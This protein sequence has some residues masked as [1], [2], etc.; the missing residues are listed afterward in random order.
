ML[1]L[2]Y[3]IFKDFLSFV[4]F[5]REEGDSAALRP[6][7]FFLPCNVFRVEKEGGGVEEKE[8]RLPSSPYITTHSKS[9]L[10]LSLLSYI[11]V[12]PC[13]HP[14]FSSL[15]GL[16]PPPIHPSIHPLYLPPLTLYTLTLLFV[17]E[18]PT[19]KSR[20]RPH[21]LG[22]FSSSVGSAEL[23]VAALVSVDSFHF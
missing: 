13:T 7:L 22:G 1:F 10:S 21:E 5:S 3:S 12:A 11:S 8:K 18:P 23:V 19:E 4:F 2:Y 6:S 9:S 17:Y 20:D 15:S 16:L 14:F